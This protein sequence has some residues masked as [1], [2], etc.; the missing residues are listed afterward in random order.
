M[1]PKPKGE[2]VHDK[3][4]PCDDKT[5]MSPLAL[6]WSKENV[7][8]SPPLYIYPL[9]LS[10]LQYFCVL[11]Y[12]QIFVETKTATYYRFLH[13]KLDFELTILP[14]SLFSAPLSC[15]SVSC[16]LCPRD[17]SSIRSSEV[18]MVCIRSYQSRLPSYSTPPVVCKVQT[19]MNKTVRSHIQN[20]VQFPWNLGLV[21]SRT[22]R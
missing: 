6:S 12:C 8:R 3:H 14:R 11:H 4:E 10:S 5:S 7:S 9:K 18:F 13:F 21:F 20:T 17:L 2:T 16:R 22:L 15:K 19:T 1:F